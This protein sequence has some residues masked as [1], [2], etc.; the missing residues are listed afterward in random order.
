MSPVIRKT[1][2]PIGPIGAALGIFKDLSLNERTIMLGLD[3]FLLLYTDGLSEAFSPEDDLYGEERLQQVL[4]TVEN[5][6]A[7]GILNALEAS[8]NQFMGPLIAADD[9]TMLA[10]KRIAWLWKPVVSHPTSPPIYSPIITELP[11]F[12]PWYNKKSLKSLK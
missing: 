11:F 1:E 8:V 12:T 3:D 2:D 6:S 9:Q 7:S 5:S 4:K 10:F